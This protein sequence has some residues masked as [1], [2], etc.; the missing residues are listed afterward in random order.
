MPKINLKLYPA[1][2]LYAVNAVIAVIVSTG[3]VSATAG[4]YLTTIASAVL[5]LVVAFATRPVVPSTI[6]AL[7]TTLITAAG[8]FG[9]HLSPSLTGL[10][11]MGVSMLAAYLTHLSVSPLAAGQHGTAAAAEAASAR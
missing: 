3:V 2:V 6:S 7:F 1:A 10:L 9:L 4:H 8:G 5:G 11:A